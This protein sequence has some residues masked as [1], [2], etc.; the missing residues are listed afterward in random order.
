MIQTSGHVRSLAVENYYIS[1]FKSRLQ[2]FVTKKFLCICIGDNTC[3]L[4]VLNG[5]GGK[6]RNVTNGQLLV[7]KTKAS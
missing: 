5:A 4:A 6:L 3:L 7:Y 1:C 2:N